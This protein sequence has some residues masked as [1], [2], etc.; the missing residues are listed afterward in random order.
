M[1]SQKTKNKIKNNIVGY[2]LLTPFLIGLIFF[3]VYP[4]A[5]ALF[6]SF[7]LNYVPR[8]AGKYD[9]ST[10]GI[11]NYT[12]A[13]QDPIVWKSLL[14]TLIYSV[15]MVPLTL[16][17][18]FAIAYVLSK[19]FAGAKIFRVLYYLSCIIPGIVTAMIY[20]YMYDSESFGFFN[21]I[22]I[23]LGLK[24]SG[25]F[26]DESHFVAMVSYMSISLFCLAG[27]MPFWIAG[28][29]SIPDGVIEAARLEGASGL[30]LVFKI[31]VPMMSKYI[32]YQLICGIIGVFQIGQG[33]LQLTKTA[34]YNSNLMFLG[35]YI[36][37]QTQG[38]EGF[39]F[40]YGSALGFILFVIIAGLTALTF[41]FN[42]FIYY[43]ADD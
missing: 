7:F 33:V 43:E 9:W 31:I 28:F 3:V 8:R 42:K 4:L 18:G 25:F 37:N 30:T 35:L 11:G 38:A 34:G 2:L 14:N 24:E 10:F 21:Q 13:F 15:V 19:D 16:A 40:G 39:N 12:Q 5:L 41:K 23:K 1:I 6:N 22:L 17:I 27:G 32:I 36:Y 29:K 20:S 26:D